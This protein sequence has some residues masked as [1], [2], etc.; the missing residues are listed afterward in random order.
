V[1]TVVLRLSNAVGAPRAVEV[2][3]WTL[4]AADLCRQAA[5]TGKLVL[6][7]DGSQRRDF[8]AL[9]DVCAVVAACIDPDRVPAGTYNLASGTPTTVLAVA[10]E[11]ADAF[12]RLDGHRPDVVPGL[13]P[14]GAH[15]AAD[16]IDVTR[17]QALGLQ[18]RPDGLRAGVE[19][20][21]AFCLEHREELACPSTA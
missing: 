6:R 4:V 7:T 3:R 19:E 8:V 5:T 10:D 15:R 21:A 14:G 12:E 16:T 20:L 2:D 17:L 11:V 9:D 1:E 18:P 13:E